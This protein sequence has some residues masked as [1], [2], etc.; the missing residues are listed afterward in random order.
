MRR[1]FRCF[2]S[3]A[4]VVAAAAL[5][6][7]S[8]AEGENELQARYA[9]VVPPSAPPSFNSLPELWGLRG[10]DKE[11]KL[12]ELD[13]SFVLYLT[14]RALFRVSDR[15]GLVYLTG[16][17]QLM[18]EEELSEADVRDHL[19]VHS[20]LCALEYESSTSAR[21]LHAAAGA[22]R[23]T[24]APSITNE[25][26]GIVRVEFEFSEEG[27]AERVLLRKLVCWNA[28]D[29]TLMS[30]AAAM[31]GF[32]KLT[33]K[34]HPGFVDPPA[35]DRQVREQESAGY[36]PD[37]HRPLVLT[38]GRFGTTYESPRERSDAPELLGTARPGLST[39]LREILS[40]RKLAIDFSDYYLDLDPYFRSLDRRHGIYYR[41]PASWP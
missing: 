22:Y 17:K 19:R 35:D 20:C 14:E 11:T 33:W 41:D 3:A 28:A 27:Q 16:G 39:W 6:G 34:E 2:V 9:L 21:E 31:P 4:G 37:D 5:A 13:E 38:D 12:A 8:P 10:L 25:A 36:T 7:Q 18:A 32:A 23:L 30:V 24:K 29:A 40:G 26:S 1:P 15:H